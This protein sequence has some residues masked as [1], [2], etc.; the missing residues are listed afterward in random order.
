MP[1]SRCLA[2]ATGF[3][4]SKPSDALVLHPGCAHCLEL[5]LILDSRFSADMAGDY[6][7]PNDGIMA[8]PECE[9][10]VGILFDMMN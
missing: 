2:H 1:G 10:L 7:I 9:Q 5:F 3:L 4:Y 8:S 6:S